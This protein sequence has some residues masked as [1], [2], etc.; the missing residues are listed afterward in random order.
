MDLDRLE[1][2]ELLGDPPPRWAVPRQGV[3]AAVRDAAAVAVE[4]YKRLL[5]PARRELAAAW[6]GSLLVLCLPPAGAQG[7]VTVRIHAYVLH[8]QVPVWLYTPQAA[9]QAARLFK[10]FPSFAEVYEFFERELAPIKVRL[11][12]VEK[13]AAAPLLTAATPR[14]ELR[15]VSTLLPRRPAAS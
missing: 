5:E 13:I 7:D 12:R 15:P 9:T 8:L 10:W 2:A 3:V 1:L 6:L 4:G 14:D 11:W